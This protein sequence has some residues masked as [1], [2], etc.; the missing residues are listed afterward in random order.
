MCVFQD[1]FSELCRACACGCDPAYN[2]TTCNHEQGALVAEALL[3]SQFGVDIHSGGIL[4][5]SFGDRQSID[6]NGYFGIAIE[7]LCVFGQKWYIYIY[8]SSF[9]KYQASSGS[10]WYSLITLIYFHVSDELK[11]LSSLNFKPIVSIGTT[12]TFMIFDVHQ[13][14]FGSENICALPMVAILG[15]L[16]GCTN[17]WSCINV[18]IYYIYIL[19]HICTIQW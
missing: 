17:S 3:V 19:I 5:A 1:F 6:K 16:S 10:F 7:S 13:L 4:L 18:Y 15:G 2:E 12:D 8:L 14:K 9:P 11:V